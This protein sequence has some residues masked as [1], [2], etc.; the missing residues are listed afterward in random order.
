MAFKEERKMTVELKLPNT[1]I[2]KKTNEQGTWTMVYD[3]G[4]EIRI[5]CSEVV[6]WPMTGRSSFGEVVLANY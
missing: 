5:G 4:M 2:N 6:G 1:A 3:E